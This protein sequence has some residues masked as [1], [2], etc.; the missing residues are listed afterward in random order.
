MT[1]R[2]HS[3]SQWCDFDF[4]PR[5]FC[6]IF[7]TL[8]RSITPGCVTMLHFLYFYTKDIQCFILLNHWRESNSVLRTQDGYFK[9]VIPG[10]LINAVALL[11]LAYSCN[12]SDKFPEGSTIMCFTE[13]RGWAFQILKLF[14][15]NVVNDNTILVKWLWRCFLVK[16]VCYGSVHENRRKVFSKSVYSCIQICY[17]GVDKQTRMA[18][19][20]AEEMWRK[21]LIAGCVQPG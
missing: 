5:H 21:R 18:H 1:S 2:V 20:C 11:S 3:S 10:F 15:L 9:L 19:Q 8:K 13:H 16:Y 7:P 6:S 12:C 14:A 4:C 17:Y